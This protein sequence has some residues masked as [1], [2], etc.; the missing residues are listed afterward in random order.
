MGVKVR[1]RK[2]GEW[3]LFI[4]HKGKRKAV[5]VGSKEAA[6]KSAKDFETA[7]GTGKLILPDSNGANAITFSETADR[8]MREHVSLKHKLSGQTYYRNILS[9]RLAPE[10]GSMK[11]SAI[12][13][14]QIKA[15][16]AKWV[17]SGKGIRSIPNFL[18]TLRAIFPGPWRRNLS[19][20][21]P[22]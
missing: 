9:R 22:V 17:E 7:L 12:T 1:E 18:R 5:K 8:W 3:W 14:G 11:L 21:T 19:P 2:P 4:D 6:K 20:S 16:V 10:F 13:R 15:T